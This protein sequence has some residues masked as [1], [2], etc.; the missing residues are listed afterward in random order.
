MPLVLLLIAVV[1][2]VVIATSRFKLHP[3]ITLLLAAFATALL[4]GMPLPDIAPTIST[5]FGDILGSIGIVIVLG[6]IIGTILE[7]TGAAITM[8]DSIIKVLGQR[9][10]KLTMSIIG[11]LVS[12]PVFC[13]SGF[14]ILN[15]L[16]RSLSKRLKVSSI[17]MSVAL[18][19]GLY[20]T[21]TFVPPLRDLLQHQVIWDSS[22]TSG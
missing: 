14:V 9:F 6:T 11:Y 18:A 21:H 7:K 10:P 1:A 17:G 4:V 5:G 20:A 12:I 16:K 8:G 3:F 15:S 19:T 13:D 22:T 2:F